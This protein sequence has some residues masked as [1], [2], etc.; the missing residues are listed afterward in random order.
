MTQV[1][2]VCIDSTDPAGLA[3]FWAEALGYR[4]LERKAGSNYLYLE[5]PGPHS[6]VFYFQEVPEAKAV[7][8]RLHLDL[9]TTA[10]AE[11]LERLEGIG[12]TPIGGR[13]DGKTCD[14]WQVL[15]DPQGNEFCVCATSAAPASEGPDEGAGL[16]AL[17]PFSQ[18]LGIRLEEAGPSRVIGTLDW[19]PDRCTAGGILHGGAFMSL[20]D[21]LGG[22]CAFLNLPDGASTATIESKTNFF[23]PVSSGLVRGT[24]APV[25]TARSTIVLETRLADGEDRPVGLVIQTQSVLRPDQR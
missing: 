11:L 13:H 19:T 14:W 18:A 22:I 3:P 7:K 8:N 16:V 15:A 21:S 23:R 20:A 4:V 6:P 5:G 25:H 1:T 9:R 2:W 17:M 12:A 10:P 24:T